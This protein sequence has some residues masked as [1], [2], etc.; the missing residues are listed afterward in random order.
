MRPQVHRAAAVR[1]GAGR[2]PLHP[3]GRRGAPGHGAAG[4]PGQPPAPDRRGAPDRDSGRRRAVHGPRGGHRSLLPGETAVSHRAARGVV[5]RAAPGPP[6]HPR[7]RPR[8]GRA[9]RH[10]LR[11]GG[12][13]RDGDP[14]GRCRRHGHRYQ[15][16]P[17]SA[18]GAAAAGTHSRPA[19]SDRRGGPRARWR[20]HPRNGR[21]SGRRSGARSGRG[22]AADSGRGGRLRA[23]GQHRRDALRSRRAGGIAA[24]LCGAVAAWRSAGSGGAGELRGSGCGFGR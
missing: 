21:S 24:H 3:A 1:V 22:R 4:A 11:A 16:R 20:G 17:V 13:N 10:R 5:V 14:V 15:R 9:A 23:R 19:L 7:N 18:A 12:G 6:G 2:L 8:N